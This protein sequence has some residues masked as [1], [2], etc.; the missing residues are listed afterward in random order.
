M[1]PR[2]IA[3]G[4]IFELYISIVCLMND[5]P[6]HFIIPLCPDFSIGYG[7]EKHRTQI[8]RIKWVHCRVPLRMGS[9]R[10]VGVR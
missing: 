9:M 7:A 6:T 5:F 3:V 4:F 10:G 1:N 2:A 8:Q